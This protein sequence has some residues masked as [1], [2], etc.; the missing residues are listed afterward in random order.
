MLQLV[1]VKQILNFFIYLR[2]VYLFI[3]FLSKILIL[4]AT[5]KLK[6]PNDVVV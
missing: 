3:C 1:K 2:V 4:K 6:F 5:S